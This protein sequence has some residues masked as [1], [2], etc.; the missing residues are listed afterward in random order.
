MGKS[1]L[2]DSAAV[3]RGVEA[4]ARDPESKGWLAEFTNENYAAEDSAAGKGDWRRKKP[5]AAMV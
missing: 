2:G 1:E 4:Q 5:N 3:V